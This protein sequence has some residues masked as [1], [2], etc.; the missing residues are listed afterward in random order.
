[1][2]TPTPH[3]PIKVLNN[4]SPNPLTPTP[5]EEANQG[6]INPDKFTFLNSNQL[7]TQYVH[8]GNV[9]QNPLT[10]TPPQDAYVPLT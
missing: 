6:R 10:P 4:N 8:K 5:T 9:L 3:P 2:P 1:M 7:I